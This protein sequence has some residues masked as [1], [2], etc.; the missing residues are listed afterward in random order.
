MISYPGPYSRPITV[1]VLPGLAGFLVWELKENWK[2]YRASRA[3]ELGPRAIG[4]HGETVGRLLRPGFH[5][6]TIPKLFTKL[7]RAAEGQTMVDASWALA[8]RGDGTFDAPVAREYGTSWEGFRIGDVNKDG[9]DD[10]VFAG[11]VLL[12]AASGIFTVVAEDL[13]FVG[14]VVLLAVFGL[15][16]W[17]ILLVGWQARDAF[18]MMIAAGLASGDRQIGTTTAR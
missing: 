14:G 9:R 18:G 10:L 15:L 13:G 8:N 3:K 1:L 7:R 6:G 2:L 17:R 11:D 4:H 12:G 16:I 5:S